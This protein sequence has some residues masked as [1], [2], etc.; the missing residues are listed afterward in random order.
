MRSAA[1]SEPA[2]AVLIPC[3]NEERTIGDVVTRFRTALP[4]AAIHVYDNNSSDLTAL[5]ARAAG[6]IVHRERRQGKGNVVRRMFADIDADEVFD[7]LGRRGE[8][9]GHV[10][11]ELVGARA[12]RRNNGHVLD[13]A[14]GLSC[15]AHNFGKLLDHALL[16]QCV[17]TLSK[18]FGLLTRRLGFG[19]TSRQYRCSFGF[20][21]FSQGCCGSDA[22]LTLCVRG[23]HCSGRCTGRFF[24][25]GVRLRVGNRAHFGVELLLAQADATLRCDLL[26]AH[27][28][29]LCNR[30]CKRSRLHGLGLRLI[31]LFL[32]R[33]VAQ[34][35]FALT[36]CDLLCGTD[37]RF[38]RRLLC[39]R[40]CDFGDLA[41]AGCLCST[42]VAN[43][44]VVVVDLFDLQGVNLQALNVESFTHRLE[45]LLLQGRPVGD[46]LG[47]RELTDDGTHRTAQDFFSRRLDL[48]LLVQESLGGGTHHGLR[49]ADLH[50]G[51]S[52]DPDGDRV[53]RL[54]CRL[55]VQLPRPQAQLEVGLND[56]L[57]EHTRAENDLLPDV[58]FLVILL[59]LFRRALARRDD[60]RLV[61]LRHLDRAQ[62]HDDDDE[63]DDNGD[64]D[65]DD[66]REELID[67]IEEHEFSMAD[68]DA[69]RRGSL[70][71]G[72]LPAGSVDLFAA[73]I[74]QRRGN[75]RRLDASHE[76]AH[77][78]GL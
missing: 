37:A 38:F 43:V 14:Q 26:L 51:D 27:D 47:H 21:F 46:D 61:G 70:G 12:V 62:Q 5:A 40:L 42:E 65:T 66:L 68:V 24:L 33:R 20:T 73:R 59:T 54:G 18:G 41:N 32:D 23:R 69:Y 22:C 39:L 35:E 72:E 78:R 16:E 6:A 10:L 8:L 29:L 76:L 45:H 34:V 11:A 1:A 75:A 60:D 49:A 17:R 55:H 3:Y 25:N 48:V 19:A 7:D 30:L 71:S 63:R 77:H 28:L 74:A 36:L 15:S 64:A 44:V 50:H 56:G 31:G 58:L 52:V 67:L 13:A 57:D 4:G 2:I 9:P 53:A